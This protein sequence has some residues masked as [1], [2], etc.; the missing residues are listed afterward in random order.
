MC[1]PCED[2]LVPLD[3]NGDS[4]AC[5]DCPFNEDNWK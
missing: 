4:A 1:D 5:A 2:C 3:E